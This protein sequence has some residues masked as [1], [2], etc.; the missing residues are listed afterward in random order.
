MSHLILR[1]TADQQ[2]I[3]LQPKE[4]VGFYNRYAKTRLRE[5]LPALNRQAANAHVS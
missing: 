1:G 5:V 2:L 3:D 4:V